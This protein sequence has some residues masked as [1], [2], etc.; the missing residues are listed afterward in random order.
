MPNKYERID[1]Y[2]RRQRSQLAERMASIKRIYL[3]TKYWLFLRDVKAGA[4]R[5]YTHQ[6]IYEKLLALVSTGSVVCPA[7]DTVLHEVF[8]QADPST[9]LMTATVID[10]LSG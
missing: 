1:D 2:V 6:L 8:R 9:R 5:S 10:E 7:S 3:D 4:P